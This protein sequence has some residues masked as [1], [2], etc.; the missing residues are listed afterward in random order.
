MLKDI[1]S[2]TGHYTF[3]KSFDNTNFSSNIDYDISFI[4]TAHTD[5]APIVNYIDSILNKNIK[6]FWYL[7]IQ[8]EW[9]RNY[10]FIKSPSFRKVPSDLIRYKP[11]SKD[12]TSEIF[13]KSSSIL[14]IEHPLQRGLTIRT[15][16]ALG[17]GKKL[18]TTN[19]NISEEDFFNPDNILI[20]DRNNI[21]IDLDFFDIPFS[22][23]SKSIRS[24]YTLSGWL[25]EIMDIVLGNSM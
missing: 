2:I 8:A 13:H 19:K 1:N 5:R 17:S 14:D 25:D 22:P 7:Y 4:G 15:F 21:S 18:I 11:V 10:Y 9:V 12:F 20:I 24:R 16:E 6:R 3:S 23:L